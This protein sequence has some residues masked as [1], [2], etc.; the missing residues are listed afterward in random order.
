MTPPISLRSPST[1]RSSGGGFTLIET[2]LAIGIVAFA[3]VG[4]MGLLPCGLQVFRQAV[5]TTLE[6]Q[7]VEHL[8][9]KV[10][11]TP[12]GDLGLL[13]GQNFYFS[14]TGD[15]VPEQSA[16]G[17][18]VANLSLNTQATLPGNESYPNGDL[19][20]VT[21][22]FKRKNEEA[23]TTSSRAFVTYIAVK[24]STVNR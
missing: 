23:S 21:I 8:V 9:A 13:Q 2:V 1:L 17:I 19:V 3:F 4:I 16:E 22:A 10:S 12:A 20:G 5:D 14:E 15:L 11:R 7:M 18:Y 6:V 24:S